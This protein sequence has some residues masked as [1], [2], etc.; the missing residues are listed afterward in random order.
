MTL[1]W[2][3]IETSTLQ[4]IEIMKIAEIMQCSRREAFT[5]CFE[6]WAWCDAE[7][8]DGHITGMSLDNICDAVRLPK[9]FCHAMAAAGWLH[10]ETDR[11]V[12]VNFMR[13]LGNGAKHRANGARRAAK[14]RGKKT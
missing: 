8:Q 10:V 4:K 3:K 11:V 13:H 9:G 5:M 2:M 12:V 6:F 14:M 1:S 7:L